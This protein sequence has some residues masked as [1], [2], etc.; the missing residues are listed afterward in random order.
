MSP[1]VYRGFCFPPEVIQQTVERAGVERRGTLGPRPLSDVLYDQIR[2]HPWLGLYAISQI[3]VALVS[4]SMG[5]HV[6]ILMISKTGCLDMTTVR[7]EATQRQ[8]LIRSGGVDRQYNEEG[9]P[10]GL[11]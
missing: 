2:L 7:E 11:L 3:G 9:N 10:L 5:Y 8:L 1:N 6:Y 4:R